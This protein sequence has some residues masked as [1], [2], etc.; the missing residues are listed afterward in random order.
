VRNRLVVP[1]MVTHFGEADVTDS[2]SLWDYLEERARGGFGVVV[3]ENLGVHASGRISPRM[4]MVDDDRHVPG[5]ARLAK[6]IRRHGAVAIG[7]INH[8]GRQN[9]SKVTGQPL[10]APSAIPCPVMKEMP[11]ALEP[12]EIVLLQEAYADAAVRLQEAG[13]DGTE[14]HAA[15]GYLAA[16]FLSSYSNRREDE[17][18]GNLPN[19]LRFL[20]GIVDRSARALAKTSCCSCERASRNSCRRVDTE[21]TKLIG[22]HSL[23][24]ESM[25]CRCPLGVRVVCATHDGLRRAEGPWLGRMAQ[26]VRG[27]RSGR[28]V[29]V[30]VD[31]RSRR[32]RSVPGR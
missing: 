20:A 18:G 16:S 8:C 11:R 1:A 3:T 22:R 9:K 27:A 29:D 4:V 13:F 31:S 23:R 5:L 2:D 28:G 24:E 21:Q 7:Q 19:R 14:I 30:S 12:D 10:L 26:C 32:P 25:S 15:H 6:A 17:Y